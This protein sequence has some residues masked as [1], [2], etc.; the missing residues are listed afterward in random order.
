MRST[1]VMPLDPPDAVMPADDPGLLPDSFEPVEKPEGRGMVDPGLPA[2]IADPIPTG[3]RIERS[4]NTEDEMNARI[5]LR[6]LKT[7]VSRE[8][9]VVDALAKAE[10][11]RTDQEKRDA[12]AAYYELYYGRIE[13]LDSSLKKRVTE[14]RNQSLNRL[15]QTR[16]DPTEPLESLTSIDRAPGRP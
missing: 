6:E 1:P 3:P 11:A 5:R 7:K 13:K 14:L 8:P 10:S 4:T 16:V 9:K 12:L 15:K 2:D